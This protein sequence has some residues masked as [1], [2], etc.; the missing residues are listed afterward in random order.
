[1]FTNVQKILGLQHFQTYSISVSYIIKFCYI[2]YKNCYL[3][4]TDCLLFAILSID[5]FT[6]FHHNTQ[7]FDTLSFYSRFSSFPSSPMM[8]FNL[9]IESVHPSNTNS[10]SHDLNNRCKGTPNTCTRSEIN[11]KKYLINFNNIYLSKNIK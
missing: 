4:F 10:F 3:P 7:C 1:M 2:E 8:L 6:L 11:T 9:L 5:A